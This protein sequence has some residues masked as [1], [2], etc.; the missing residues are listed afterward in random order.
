MAL[1]LILLIGATANTT[2]HC[3]IQQSMWGI[4]SLYIPHTFT[5][6]NINFH[7]TPLE[8]ATDQF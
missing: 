3:Q 6:T 8:T 7:S 1:I 2:D 4:L 5:E